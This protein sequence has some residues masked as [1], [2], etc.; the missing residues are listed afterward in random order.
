MAQMCLIIVLYFDKV[1]SYRHEIKEGDE[2]LYINMPKL[3]KMLNTELQTKYL[4]PYTVSRITESHAVI[5]N[6]KKGLIKE[7]K[8][9]IDIIKKESRKIQLTLRKRNSEW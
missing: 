4:G 6:P 7:K 8:I 5:P 3:K 9:P 2:I 1:N